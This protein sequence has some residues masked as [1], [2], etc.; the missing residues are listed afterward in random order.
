MEAEPRGQVHVRVGMG[1]DLH[2]LGPI[3]RLAG[4]PAV[5]PGKRAGGSQSARELVIGGVKFGGDLGPIAHSDGDALL[6]ALTD[7]ILGAAGL[8]DIGELFPDQDPRWAGADSEIFLR[9]AITLARQGGWRVVNIDAT[10]ILERPKL[11][12][13]KQEVRDNL[14]RMLEVNASAVNVKGKTHELLNASAQPQ[15]ARIEAWVVAL[16]EA[17]GSK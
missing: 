7:A 9:E 11:S 16:L 1:Y 3:S 10:V 5:P 17:A 12:P 15:E 8:P 13:R 2:R 6:H 4:G 14:A